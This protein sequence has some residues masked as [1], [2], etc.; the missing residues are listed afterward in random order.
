MILQGKAEAGSEATT[1]RVLVTPA[2]GL[3]IAGDAPGVNSIDESGDDID[4]AHQ[5]AAYR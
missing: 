5:S 2:M 1:G 3:P 4:R